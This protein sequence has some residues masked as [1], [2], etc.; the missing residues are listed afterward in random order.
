[1]KLYLLNYADDRFGHKGGK[2]LQ[3]QAKLNESARQQ[4]IENIV[5]WT[6]PKLAET[7]FYTENQEYL[8]KNRFENGAVWK[9]FIVQNLLRKI[10]HGDIIFYYDSG[11]YEINRPVKILTD[12]CLRNKG[13][14]FHEWGEKNSKYTKRDAFVYMDCDSPRY[15]NAVALQNT[16]FLLQKTSFTEK[17]VD[18]WL[19]YNLDE[20]I[21]SY[22]KPNT[23]GLPDIIGFVENRGDQSIFSNL[24]V[25]YKIRTFPGVGGIQN[26]QVDNFIDSLS[27]NFRAKNLLEITKS[28]SKLWLGNSAYQIRM[29][30]KPLNF[31]VASTSFELYPHG[32]AVKQFWL[33][34][35]STK[36]LMKSLLS[37]VDENSNVVEV[38]ANVGL[39][40]TAIAKNLMNGRLLAVEADPSLCQHLKANLAL[41]SCLDKVSIV[42]EAL[43]DSL[44]TASLQ[45]NS[46]WRDPF[47]TIGKPTDKNCQIIATKEVKA[48]TLTE[49]LDQ[50]EFPRPSILLIDVSGAELPVLRGATSL[51]T[52]DMAPVVIYNCIHQACL[53]FRYQH[54]E[55]QKLL[56]HYGY[57]LFKLEHP[58]KLVEL[59]V[60]SN[61]QGFIYSFKTSL[62]GR[63]SIQDTFSFEGITPTQQPQI[64]P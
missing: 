28:K 32:G 50:Y 23:C 20:R 1:M 5:S 46:P 21:A 60:D 52:S 64:L 47:N 49:V 59:S 27:F 14:L 15:H 16:W 45:V 34:N 44:G 12:I 38:G 10:E 8:D 33:G 61:H 53:G 17:F 35:Y 22:V 36:Q 48:S 62:A 25:K 24:A 56:R 41:N 31:T 4:G 26:R 39:T 43:S 63:T 42:Q 55:T 58:Q 51:L 19:K 7:S 57:R 37:L 54:T 29:Q 3:N 30:G 9:P 40:T 6:W 11:S 13:T 18:E 2:F